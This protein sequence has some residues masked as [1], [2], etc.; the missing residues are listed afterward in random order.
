MEHPSMQALANE[1]ILEV[2]EIQDPPPD[3][4]NGGNGDTTGGALG[5]DRVGGG[6]QQ[7]NEP[8]RN[9]PPNTIQPRPPGATKA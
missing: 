6:V 2:V 9:N 1:G 3:T 8:V 4:L 7:P 5:R